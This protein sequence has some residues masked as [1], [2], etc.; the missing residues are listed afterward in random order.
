MGVHIK[1]DPRV[2]HSDSPCGFCLSTG[3]KC[4]IRL[5][6]GRGGDHVAI[7][8]MVN[9]RCPN[10]RSIRISNAATFTTRQPCTNHPLKCPICP[11]IVWKY[12]LESHIKVK[13]RTATLDHHKVHFA[14]SDAEK[15]ALE[16]LY[17]KK[18]RVA[19][20]TTAVSILKV[21]DAHS[22]RNALV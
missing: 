14:F 13:H 12:N 1:N 4:E 2:M 16:A 20:K 8:D 6:R 17:N 5:S 19:K 10:L 15:R 21:S 18:T 7:I 9:S 22:S 3:S 11:A